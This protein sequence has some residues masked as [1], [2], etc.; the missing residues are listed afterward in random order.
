[1]NKRENPGDGSIFN[2]RHLG[3]F[4]GSIWLYV[5]SWGRGKKG[6][7]ESRVGEKA[8]ARFSCMAEEDSV[9]EIAEVT[10]PKADP[11]QDFGLVVAAFN[12]TV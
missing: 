1:M 3:I 11:F 2:Y 10:H 4:S 7:I 5:N 6:K 12:K 9:S 8:P